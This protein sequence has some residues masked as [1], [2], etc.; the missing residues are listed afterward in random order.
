LF[1][2]EIL[3]RTP[4]ATI[5]L[6]GRAAPA[7]IKKSAAKKATLDALRAG[8]AAVGFAASLKYSDG[9]IVIAR[10]AAAFHSPLGFKGALKGLALAGAVALAVVIVTNPYLFADWGTFTH[11]L[12]RQR[13]FASGPALLGQPE[14]NGW[15]YYVTSSRWALGILPA[16][17]AFIGGVALL[18]KDKRREAIVLG[19]VV[20]L[21]YLYMG[22]QSR[23]YARWML[24][25]YPA[26]AILAAYALIQV[27]N[28]VVFG[29]LT[30][31]ML[32]PSTYTTVRNATV[33]GRE[34]TRTI[35]RDWLMAHV[36]QGTKV[37]FEP[38]APTE[39]YGE[40][41]GGG[42][43]ADPARRWERWTRSSALIAELGRDFRGARY[44]ANFQNYE[45]TLE[46]RLI[47]VYRREHACW[48]V[49]GS[50]Q[51]GRARA[52]PYRV[53]E[54]LEYY[55]RLRSESTRAFRVTPVKPGAKL[56]R[57]QVDKSFNYVDGAYYRPGPA[58]IVYKLR[59]CT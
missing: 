49:T 32:I 52:E 23:F 1:A 4:N 18:V 11:D 10:V 27:R 9:A 5:V 37:V 33:M 51:Y 39:W 48:I 19:S 15:L 31:L 13:K 21:Y 14:R 30:A 38:I 6:T 22:S 25:L 53:P 2:N 55:R 16:V 17:L 20:V 46:P 54:A 36:P 3:V 43:K 47:D 44:P 29:V 12:D 41:P 50:T 26:L 7:E 35:T 56:P 24:P 58:I 45:R 42:P 57:Y 8:G 40:T 59:D 28:K 34:D